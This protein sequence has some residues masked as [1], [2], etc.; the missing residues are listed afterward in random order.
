MLIQRCGHLS[1]DL[2]RAWTEELPGV[3]PCNSLEVPLAYGDPSTNDTLTARNCEPTALA[4]RGGLETEPESSKVRA[5]VGT[6]SPVAHRL[7]EDRRSHSGSVIADPYPG[8]EPIELEVDVDM[9]GIGRDAVVDEIGD[10]GGKV[11]PDVPKG[12]DEA[13]CGG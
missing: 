7:V 12:V 1:A 8:V 5:P 13:T 2:A 4:Q 3:A 11:I 9:S 10:G 6:L